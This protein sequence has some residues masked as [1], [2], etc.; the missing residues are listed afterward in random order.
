LSD[1][2]DSAARGA[3]I[4][5]RKRDHIALCHTGPVGLEG[6]AG[7][8]G[9]VELVH[10]AL[11]ELGL[12]EV[13]LS[14]SLF[15]RG[16]SAPVLVTGMTGGPEEAGEI[17]RAVARVCERLGVAFGVG[18]QRV[19]TRDAQS[20]STFLVRREA[21]SVPILANIGVNQL[22]D[23]G[24]RRVL[25]LVEAIEA[26]GLAVHLNPAMELAQGDRDADRDFR[27]GYA[28]IAEV[29]EALGGRVMV[30]E[31]GCGLSPRVVERLYA[32]A[33]EGGAGVRAMDLSG[34]GGTSWVKLE[35]LRASGA[36]AS[37]GHL[38]AGWGVPTAAAVALAHG[39]REAMGARGLTLVASGGVGDPLVAAKALA[40]G[41]DL[42]GL[43]RPLLRALLDEGEGGAERF[44]EELIYGLRVVVALTGSR[45]LA[46]LRRAPVVLGPRLSA[47]VAQ[48]GRER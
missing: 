19:I 45:D 46:S 28:A 33:A 4:H 8:W 43:A 14:A 16:L 32:P 35:A 1:S 2:P 5:Q 12:Q 38:L 34:V 42:V 30:K 11:P 37:L 44:L 20:L 48:G 24:V 18:S 6:D 15:G 26:D 10:D 41:A 27:G 40:L 25:E 29:T 39:R 22:R 9:E 31:C 17:N 23:L 36:R 7:L 3:D 13:D 47:W 21:P